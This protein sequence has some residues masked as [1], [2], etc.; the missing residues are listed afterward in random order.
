MK[1]FGS[2]TEYALVAAM[3]LARHYNP[4]SPVR[5]S[6]IA[7]RTG[8][9]EKFLAQILLNLKER[10]LV[11]SEKGPG[12]GYLLMRRPEMISVA[13]IVAAASPPSDQRKRELPTSPYSDAVLWLREELKAARLKLLSNIDLAQFARRAEGTAS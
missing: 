11:R 13:E 9:P 12:G 7:R 10:A 5:A 8:A 4:D 6:D 3:D 2:K 1:S